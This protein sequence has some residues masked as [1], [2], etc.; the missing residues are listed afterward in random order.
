MLRRNFITGKW[1][2]VEDGLSGTYA[3][4]NGE[5]VRVSGGLRERS[6]RSTLCSKNPWMSRSVGVHPKRAAEVNAT[7]KSLGMDF[8]INEK[9]F[10]TASS[11]KGKKDAMRY[12]GMHNQDGGYGDKC[13]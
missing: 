12:F 7:A 11:A 3:Y 5:V 10:A 8:K 2:E 6:S 13:P 9:G 1:E 4:R